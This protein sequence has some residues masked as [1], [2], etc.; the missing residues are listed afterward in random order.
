VLPW[1]LDKCAGCSTNTTPVS[2]PLLVVLVF[3]LTVI[4]FSFGLFAPR[5]A[6]VVATLLIC[7]LSIS[8]AIL[9]ILEMYHPYAGL[10]KISD[11]PLRSALANLLQ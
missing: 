4:F 7:A 8:G 1:V 5:N 6:T 2:V 3:W 10:I 11:A 9:L